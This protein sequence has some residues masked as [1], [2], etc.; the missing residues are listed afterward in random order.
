MASSASA[1]A[2][3]RQRAILRVL[4][5]AQLLIWIDGT[6]L[7]NAF[8]TLADPVRG[9]GATP[10]E[11]QWATGAYTLVFATLSFTGGALGDRF[12]YRNTLV[13]GMALFGVASGCA[14]YAQTPGQLIAARCA[15]GVGA[16]LLLPATMAVVSW[17]FEPARRPAAFAML[18]SFAG[19]GIAAGP[20]LSGLLLSRLWWGSVFIVN[21][22]V[23]VVGLVCVVTF[24]PNF[25]SP[26]ARSLDPA[27][28][29]LSTAGL[30]LVT[31]GLI[32]AGQDASAGSPLVWVSLAAGVAVIGVFV[33]VELR[34]AQPSFDPRLLAQRRFASGN[35]ALMLIFLALTSSSYYLAF[36]LQGPRHLSALAAGCVGLPGA[37]MVVAAAPIGTRLVRRSSVGLVASIALAVATVNTAAFALFGMGTSLAWYEVFMV[38][39]GLSIGMAIPVLSGMVLGSLPMERAG[40]GS[41]V[42][43]TLRQAGSVLGIAVG[44]TVSSVVYRRAI[45]PAL[46][47]RPESVRGRALVSAE[48][49][50]HAAAVTRDSGLVGAADR[51]FVHAAHVTSL[52]TAGFVMAAAVVVGMGLPVRR[53]V[54]VAAAESSPNSSGIPSGSVISSSRT[55]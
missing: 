17:T 11:L 14:A 52:W 50:R 31:Y 24:V 43:S 28:L 51:A 1:V 49:A 22:P 18:S 25:R 26:Q 40:A 36:Y 8:E 48:S 33:L 10:G 20:I 6:I 39:Q 42:N 38:V 44:G 55:P 15:M 12:G 47:D 30:A 34:I 53:A 35:V 45:G 21:I 9:L 54:P 5:F 29:M 41:A 7:T 19:V 4:I 37:L 32:R 46:A 27:G 23:V 2:P 13:A 16:A 3:T